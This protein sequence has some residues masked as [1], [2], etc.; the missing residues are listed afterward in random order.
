[1]YE[2]KTSFETT[3]GVA[4]KLSNQG[5]MI[6]ETKIPSKGKFESLSTS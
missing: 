1:M 2:E 5:A 6:E 4:A 3:T